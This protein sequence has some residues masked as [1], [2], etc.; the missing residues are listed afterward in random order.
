MEQ[1]DEQGE[2]FSK[3]LADS[4]GRSMVCGKAI[5]TQSLSQQE[6]FYHTQKESLLENMTV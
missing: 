4:L 6:Q 5:P 1:Y 2:A 3:N